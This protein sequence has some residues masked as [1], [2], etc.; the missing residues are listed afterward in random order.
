MDTGAETVSEGKESMRALNNFLLSSEPIQLHLSAHEIEKK[1]VA[2]TRSF[3][4]IFLFLATRQCL[5]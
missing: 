3:K 2:G 1:I 4:G 5:S